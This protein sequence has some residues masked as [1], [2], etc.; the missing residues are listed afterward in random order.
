[1]AGW[2]REMRRID[3]VVSA[4]Q[5]ADLLSRADE[6]CRD[7]GARLTSGRRAVLDILFRENR[8]ISA[9][10]I[11]KQLEPVLRRQLQP[12]TIHRALIFL[13]R[14]RLIAR[15]ASRNT[16]VAIDPRH[17]QTS[18]FMSCENCGSSLRTDN[19]L[20]V[21]QD[22]GDLKFRIRLV[23]LLGTCARCLQN[24][25]TGRRQFAL[26]GKSRK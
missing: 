21:E 26:A 10:E 5:V 11:R 18:I 9:S 6:M 14:H 17:S 12:T 7:R 15:L 4:S 20:I 19:F 1:V 24:G 2:W 16:F 23:E 13:L 8:A 25:N 3:T 22:A